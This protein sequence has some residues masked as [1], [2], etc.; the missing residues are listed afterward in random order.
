MLQ[1]L[2]ARGRPRYPNKQGAAYLLHQLALFVLWDLRYSEIIISNKL[3]RSKGKNDCEISPAREANL[4]IGKSQ[5]KVAC[6]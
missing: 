2:R 6:T 5:K 3:R 4:R 1:A